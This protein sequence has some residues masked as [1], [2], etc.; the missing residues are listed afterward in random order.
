MAWSNGHTNGKTNGHTPT[1]SLSYVGY[2]N[3][4]IASIIEVQDQGEYYLIKTHIGNLDIQQLHVKIM[5]NHLILEGL[6]SDVEGSMQRGRWVRRLEIDTPV[7]ETYLD[8]TYDY[9][10]ALQI[11]VSKRLDG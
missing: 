1:A 5:G 8:I 2:S 11:K 7:E 6:V 3:L 4:R 10:G 9:G